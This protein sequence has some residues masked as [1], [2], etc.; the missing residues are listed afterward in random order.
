MK[1]TKR[2]LC[3]AVLCLTMLMSVLSFVPANAQ[4]LDE[5][6]KTDSTSLKTVEDE[7]GIHFYGPTGN[8]LTDADKL[9]EDVT[10]IDSVAEYKEL[11][12][13]S[14]SKS[15]NSL[16][17]KATKLPSSVDNSQSIYFPEIGDQQDL[18]SCLYWAQIYYQYTYEYNRAN[19]IPTT[20][21]NVFSPQ[22]SY[23]V[24]TA[25]ED[26]Q[27]TTAISLNFMKYQ[28]SVPMSQV[29][30]DQ[31]YLNA[32]PNEEVWRNS[33][34]YRLKE[35]HFF[36]Q[37]GRFDNPITS[38]DDSDLELIKTALN[39]GEIL[40]YS[41]M[42]L[43][44]SHT[45]IIANS[46][47]PENDDHVGEVAVTSMDSQEGGH[48]MTLVGYNDNIWIDVNKNQRVD[49]GEM[50][51]FKIANS[52]GTE[53]GN[54]GFAWVAY[55][56][57]ND[58][59]CVSGVAPNQDRTGIF[60]EVTRFEL[61]PYGEK[62]DLYLKYT[63]NTSDRTH[64]LLQVTAE[65]D[66]TVNTASAMSNM[67][68]GLPL[69]YDGSTSATDATMIFP[70]QS[71]FPD[72]TSENFTDYTWNVKIKDMRN[73]G[74][75][76]TVKDVVIVDEKAGKTY[77]VAD[78]YPLTLDGDEEV[79]QY[80][81]SDL[82]HA[83]VY[84]RGFYEPNLFYKLNKS[85]AQW[86]G[87]AVMTQCYEE[88]GYTHK[89]VID[90]KDCDSAIIYFTGEDG[91]IDNNYSKYFTV[92][93]GRNTFVTENMAK[94]LS[95]SMTNDMNSVADVGRFGLFKTEPAGGYEPYTFEYIAT[96]L[97]TGEETLNEEHNDVMR[98]I[99][100]TQEGD[101]KVV[102]KLT[103]CAGTVAYA[104]N[105]LSIV[106][107]PFEFTTFE[108]KSDYKTL[109]DA[110]PITFTAIT[111]YENIGLRYGVYHDYTLKIEHDGFVIYSTT[112]PMIYELTD[113][114][115]MTSTVIATWTPDTPG[116]YTATISATDCAGEYAE[117][118]INFTVG[119]CIIG[120]ADCNGEV[121]IIDSTF[122]QMCLAHVYDDNILSII[123]A[124]ADRDSNITINDATY[125]Q[126][127]LANVPGVDFVGTVL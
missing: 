41:T 98:G 44:W 60:T 74:V 51:A 107:I 27:C 36:E 7:Y 54:E 43:G 75:V 111:N 47:A 86:Q 59:S 93:K 32:H 79:V 87:D 30:Y 112:I 113:P 77:Q 82:N 78:T 119:K 127:Y 97:T 102:V 121:N 122:L 16:I 49:K 8:N 73:D 94:P 65:K 76:L 13:N 61:L 37:I 90:L 25:G 9:N 39:N 96:N 100:F 56:A 84:Y 5:K 64:V 63:L 110:H 38:P 11:A 92:T 21:D 116:E 80:H 33:I 123:T 101:Y 52:W 88:K 91:R 106:S 3:C 55:D 14:D 99:Y 57:L 103:D 35:Y 20:P 66:L 125:I 115:Y 105:Y 71:V 45:E 53:Y 117:K 17:R 70:L 28:G 58:T 12:G 26:M 68:Y 114:E 81:E 83:V 15:S 40:S 42:M 126:M 19:G 10:V 62:T 24:A 67:N 48:R 69:A 118:T 6:T 120:D 124:D 18:G 2:R 95:I 34:N 89:A 109:I 50:G 1:K 31:D 22:W 108:A 85:D 72:V 29:P 23:N 46:M 4:P 104:E